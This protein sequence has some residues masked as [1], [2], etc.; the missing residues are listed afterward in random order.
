MLRNR[1]P[2]CW[3]IELSFEVL[4]AQGWHS[5]LRLES[6]YEL[7]I[8]SLCFDVTLMWAWRCLYRTVT[9]FGGKGQGQWSLIPL[10]PPS[11]CAVSMSLAARKLPSWWWRQEPFSASNFARCFIFPYEAS[12]LH[13]SYWCG[14]LCNTGWLIAQKLPEYVQTGYTFWEFLCRNNF[15]T[16]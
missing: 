5:A 16:W 12:K 6:I 11:L 8:C 15:K 4:M 7:C 14:S 9:S 13:V 2:I 10:V 1:I 3:G